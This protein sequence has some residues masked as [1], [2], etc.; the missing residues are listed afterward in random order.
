MNCKFKADIQA[1]NLILED[2]EGNKHLFDLSD[3]S[4]SFDIRNRN[5]IIVDQSGEETSV[6]QIEGYTALEFYNA[7]AAAKL[8][9]SA[10]PSGAPTTGDSCNNPTFM[11]VCNLDDI[12]VGIEKDSSPL[13]CTVDALGEIT[14]KVF[15]VITA[16]E[17]GST[18]TKTLLHVALDGTITDPWT[19]DW[20]NCSDSIE[21]VLC[22][23]EEN[24]GIY[25]LFS[26]FSN[27]HPDAASYGATFTHIG[28]IPTG[29]G[30]THP[31]GVTGSINGWSV[32][33]VCA[34]ALPANDSNGH[35]WLAGDPDSFSASVSF[36]RS[37]PD[38]AC[39]GDPTEHMPTVG[40][41]DNRRDSLLQEIVD[42]LL[43]TFNKVEHTI[44]SGVNTQIPAGFKS[45]RIQC[46]SGEVIINGVYH[47]QAAYSG[48]GN[49]YDRTIGFDATESDRVDTCLPAISIA[50]SPAGTWEWISLDNVEV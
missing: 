3:V 48:V 1:C 5:V 49:I 14:G 33:A 24:G 44:T 39:L 42:E 28:D 47:L 22:S 9:C 27:P 23:S 25:T 4:L 19:G 7:L 18:S 50:G 31:D 13:G 35:Q 37:N 6:S 12:L 15:L 29:S 46:T 16:S 45:V 43:D 41:N 30:S 10:V 11:N 20:V 26:K 38:P 34:E 21:P 17:D 2:C 32:Y 40:C 8:A 36:V